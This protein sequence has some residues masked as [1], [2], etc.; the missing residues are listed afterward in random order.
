MKPDHLETEPG[1]LAY[2][3][4]AAINVRSRFMSIVIFS[5]SVRIKK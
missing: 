1:I 5:F 2:K 3:G 4:R